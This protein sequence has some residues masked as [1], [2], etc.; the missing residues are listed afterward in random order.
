M[1]KRSIKKL[2][3]TPQRLK[4]WRALS[5]FGRILDRSTLWH[6]NRV[7]IARAT[8]VG[9]FCAMIPLPGQMLIAVYIA[10]KVEANL[11]LSFSLIFITNPLT[12]PG[13]YLGAY[14][15][16]VWLMGAPTADIGSINWLEPWSDEFLAI[17]P[18]FLLGCFVI[19][20][21]AALIGYFF[22]DWIWRLRVQQR[23]SDRRRRER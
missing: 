7:S 5:I 10:I 13:I 21:I 2:L 19:G 12:M 1:P 3:P 4:Q 9:L 20:C 23:W 14:L 18:P 17:W 15:V 8:A 22:V 11:P 6:V 16:G